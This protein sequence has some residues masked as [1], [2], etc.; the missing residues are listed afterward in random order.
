M[1]YN[2]DMERV[3]KRAEEQGWRHRITEKGHHQFFAPDN[4]PI[5]VASGTTASDTSWR[6]F[7]ADMKRAGFEDAPLGTLGDAFPATPTPSKPNGGGKLSVTQYVIDLVA[8]HPEG[9]WPQEVND[10][11]ATVR[12]DVGRS[13]HSQALFKLTAQGV[14]IRENGKYKMKPIETVVAAAT[15]SISVP[16]IT[17]EEVSMLVG[18]SRTGDES[19]D[20]D[21][22]EL[23][24]SLAAL[25]RIE[26]VVKRTREKL[27]QIANLKKLLGAVK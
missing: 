4:G 18:G 27:Q 11:I 2:G 23:D 10:Y 19:I 8:R 16:K 15:A 22:Q 26:G 7:L 20:V 17:A 14:F 21:L 1:S 6:H 3:I 9:V 25:A 12:P 24:D 5:I 13:S